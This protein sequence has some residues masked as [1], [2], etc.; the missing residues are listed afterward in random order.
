MQK[1]KELAWKG[2]ERRWCG[3]GSEMF[4]SIHHA[5]EQAAG[6]LLIVQVVLSR[7]PPILNS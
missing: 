5:H 4:D 1:T 2:C 3:I 7:F 6:F